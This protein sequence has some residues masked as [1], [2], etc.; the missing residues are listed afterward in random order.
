MPRLFNH[1]RGSSCGYSYNDEIWFI[2]HLVSSSES[3][4]HYYHLICVFD[5]N[6]KL[7]R[8]TAPFKFFNS[9]IEYSLGII[10]EQKKGLITISQYDSTT[11][12]SVYSKDYIENIFGLM[13]LVSSSEVLNKFEV[14]YNNCSIRYGDMKKQLGADMVQFIKPIR[15][16]AES[17][18]NDS[19]Y[20]KEV[21]EKGA[22][23]ARKSAAATME[24][25][26]AAMGLNYF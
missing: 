25:V 22:E 7:L 5:E 9:C 3:P 1:I 14:D 21:M 11:N 15:E 23:K 26:R 12:I 17:L 19:K 6:M 10:V 4:R 18:R 20:L 16:K 24:S 13:K 8:Y 2:V